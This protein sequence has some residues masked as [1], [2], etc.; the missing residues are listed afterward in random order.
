MLYISSIIT[1][2]QMKN[3][4]KVN[5]SITQLRYNDAIRKGT[6]T[7]GPFDIDGVSHYHVKWD[8]MGVGF[9]EIV[10]VIVATLL[11]FRKKIINKI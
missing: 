2:K 9:F 6:V 7:E 1:N 11:L 10:V 4:F 3:R 8:V 5:D